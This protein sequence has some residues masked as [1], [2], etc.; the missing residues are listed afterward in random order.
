MFKI[1]KV[2]AWVKK[3]QSKE[4]HVFMTSSPYRSTWVYQQKRLLHCML[5]KPNLM[6]GQVNMCLCLLSPNESLALIWTSIHASHAVTCQRKL[7]K[8][9]RIR[10]GLCLKTLFNLLWKILSWGYIYRTFGDFKGKY[11]VHCLLCIPKSF[12]LPIK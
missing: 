4:D 6:V 2:N 3:Q 11:E 8:L 12:F 5:I 1:F 7:N 10:R 9:C